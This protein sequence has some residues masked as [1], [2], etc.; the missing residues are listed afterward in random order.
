[1]RATDL[2]F[3]ANFPVRIDVGDLRDELF[4]HRVTEGCDTV[5]H[6]GNHPNALGGLSPQRLLAE[7]STMN[8]HFFLLRPVDEITD[9]ADGSALV[10]DLDF[11][12]K[13]RVSLTLDKG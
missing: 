6:L 5:V 13:L 9:F 2:R 8:A 7:N 4:V 10:R 11:A 12:P 3:A 1:M